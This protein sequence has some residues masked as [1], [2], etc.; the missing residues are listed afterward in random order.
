MHLLIVVCVASAVVA[1]Q[2]PVPRYD[3]KRASA[4][5]AMVTEAGRGGVG[6]GPRR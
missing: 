3:V 4:P 6:G 2:A 5:P 1:A